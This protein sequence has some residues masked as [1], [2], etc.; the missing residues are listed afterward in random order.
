MPD[1]HQTAIVEDGARLGENVRVGAFSMIGPE[2]VLEDGV[3]VHSHALVTGRTRVG[4]GSAIH[5]FAAIGGAPQDTSYAGEPTSVVIGRNCIVREHAT[6]NRGTARGKGVTTVGDNCFLMIGAHVAHDCLVGD[7]VVMVN[8]A[9][10]GGH[11]EI[12]ERAILGG[13]SAVQQRCRI[14]AHA[15]IGGLTGVA[16]DV[17]PYAMAIGERAKLGGLNI[18]GLK[19]R[20]FDRA[21]IHALRAAYQAIFNGDGGRAERIDAVAREYADVPPVMTIVDFVRSGGDRP[22]CAPRERR[23]TDA[24]IAADA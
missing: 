20:G 10:L 14:G 13:L 3:T 5:P 4:A 12:G 19:R 8:S 1:I 7:H 21:T 22:L 18:I 16:T 17:I 11:V 24:Q 23:L 6:I 9:T 2:V 15:F